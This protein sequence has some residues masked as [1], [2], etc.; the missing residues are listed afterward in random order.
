[1][2]DGND[3]AVMSLT[4]H[5]ACRAARRTIAPAALEYVLTDGRRIQRYPRDLL[6]AS[7]GAMCRLPIAGPVGPLSW[8]AP[9]SS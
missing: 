5:V 6:F 8:K 9:W 3:L 7:A 2:E 4:T 1:M